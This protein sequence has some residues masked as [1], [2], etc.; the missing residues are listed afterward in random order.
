M[1][2]A[3]VMGTAM[4]AD[5]VACVA[6]TSELIESQSVVYFESFSAGE[7]IT[8][9]SNGS[10]GNYLEGCALD[11]RVT[12]S[13]VAV[14]APISWVEGIPVFATDNPNVGIQFQYQYNPRRIG[15]GG[16]IWSTWRDLSTTASIINTASYAGS[17]PYTDY[18]GLNYRAR[19]VA[20]RSFSGTQQIG[21]TRVAHV[22]D[23]T[24][25][26]TLNQ[27]VFESFRLEAPRHRSCGFSGTVDGRNIAMPFTHTS[28]LP[29]KGDT[30]RAAGFS[31]DFRCDYGN[32]EDVTKAM[33]IDY[34][35]GT[36][37][38][39]AADGRMRVTG[40]AQGVDLQVRRRQDGD[41]VPV[42]LRSRAWVRY[43]A[44]TGSEY[45]EV[46]YIRNADPLIPGVANGALKIYIEPW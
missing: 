4:A 36:P 44:E 9:W 1:L 3:A 34:T 5:A 24:F 10:Q 2:A 29:N 16:P 8:K 42:D 38:V 6:D 14:G 25:G 32:I 43:D 30:S 17:W 40:G 33:G 41:M 27:R 39:D 35:A 26:I 12:F 18:A 45:L 22:T 37:V 13:V 19:F 7:V 23:L 46:R 15:T 28:S 20:I 21:R 31:W 11:T